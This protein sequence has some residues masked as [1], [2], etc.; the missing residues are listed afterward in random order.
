MNLSRG[1]NLS[2]RSNSLNSASGCKDIWIRNFEFATK[3]QS[4]DLLLLSSMQWCI[5]ETKFDILKLTIDL[6]ITIIFLH[7]DIIKKH[8]NP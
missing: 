4:F 8:T 3:I 5:S 2:R 7:K 1:L 6:K